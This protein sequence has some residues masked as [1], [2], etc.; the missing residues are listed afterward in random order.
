MARKYAAL[1]FALAVAPS[2][3]GFAIGQEVRQP[4]S[5]EYQ[6]EVVREM[7][8]STGGQ[9]VLR[10]GWWYP[11]FANQGFGYDKIFHKHGITNTD[12]VAGTVAQPDDVINEGGGRYVHLRTLIEV[13]CDSVGCVDTDSTIIRI[14]IDYSPWNAAPQYGQLGVNTAYCQEEPAVVRCDSWVNEL[15]TA[16]ASTRNADPVVMAEWA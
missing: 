13:T 3:S 9:A 16:P 2:M 1:A 4:P 8:N 12:V 5:I 11:E 10:R 15:G 14:V 6:A 7:T